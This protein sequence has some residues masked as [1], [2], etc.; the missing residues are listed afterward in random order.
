M[1]LW[2]AMA[3]ASLAVAV[4]AFC[5]ASSALRAMVATSSLSAS[6]SSGR[7]EMAASMEES[8][9]SSTPCRK[10]EMRLFDD[11]PAL[12]GRHV[13]WGFLQSIPS[14]R[15]ASCEGVSDTVPSVAEGHTNRPFSSRLA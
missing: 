8:E 1:A 11:Y 14:S 7:G 10:G 3:L 12:A 13:Y 9:S 6:T 2:W 4:A 5:S 15:Q